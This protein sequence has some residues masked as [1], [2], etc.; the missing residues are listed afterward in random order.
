MKQFLLPLACM[1]LLASAA[2]VQAAAVTAKPSTVSAFLEAY[3]LPVTQGTDD[4][5]DPMLD[6]RINGTHF[7]VYFYGCR[8]NTNC[9][10]IQF[11]TGYDLDQPMSATMINEWNRNNRF[12]R[13]YLD[14]E[15]DPFLEMDINLDGD[16]V[17]EKNFDVSL[18]LWKAVTRDFE[19]FIDW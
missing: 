7:S 4:S 6:S 2:T 10:T 16:G 5:G 19:H 18:D 3:G 11:S 8:G 13:A 9:R 17:N 12:G 14:D 1:G 15:G